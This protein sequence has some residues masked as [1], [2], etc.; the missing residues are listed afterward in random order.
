MSDRDWRQPPPR[1][2]YQWESALAHLGR[3]WRRE[4]RLPS[5]HEIHAQLDMT[6]GFPGQQNSPREGAFPGAVL[7]GQPVPAGGGAGG[8]GGAGSGR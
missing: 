6:A 4:P 5:V 8:A 3:W 1:C 7:W 2:P